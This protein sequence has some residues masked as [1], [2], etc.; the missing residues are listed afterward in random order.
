MEQVCNEKTF[1]VN[2]KTQS[3]VSKGWQ[4]TQR[5]NIGQMETEDN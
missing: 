5:S 1:P 3:H 4:K 2:Q